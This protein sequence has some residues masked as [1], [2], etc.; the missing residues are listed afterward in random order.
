[1]IQEEI[2]AQFDILRSRRIWKEQSVSELLGPMNM[3][4]DRTN[5]AFERWGENDLFLEAEIIAKSNQKIR[6]LLLEKGYLIPPNLLIDASKLIEHYDRWLQEY[7]D[8]RRTK[9][10][11]Q[12]DKFTF[13][14]TKGFEFPRKS[15]DKFQ[16]IFK[17]YW[18]ELYDKK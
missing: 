12:Q 14:G 11:K 4:L 13:V 2:R 10:P 6:D 15:A 18:E 3:L 1:M 7:D 16:K 8:N 17:E 5:L 9:E